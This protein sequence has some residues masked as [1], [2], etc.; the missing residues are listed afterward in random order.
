MAM[1]ARHCPVQLEV[2][3]AGIPVQSINATLDHYLIPPGPS[4]STPETYLQVA[5][6]EHVLGRTL[7]LLRNET[8]YD[9]PM[10]MEISQN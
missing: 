3:V 5:V 6:V 9:I 8:T 4:A 2:P 1:S 10:G 7:P